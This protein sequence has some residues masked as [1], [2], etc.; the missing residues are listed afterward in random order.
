LEFDKL[1]AVV[2]QDVYTRLYARLYAVIMLFA[3]AQ[4][5]IFIVS[6]TLLIV[7]ALCAS[8]LCDECFRFCFMR[9]LCNICWIHF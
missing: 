5:V 3:Y 4:S 9:A 6:F 8:Y 2:M 1:Y 7:P